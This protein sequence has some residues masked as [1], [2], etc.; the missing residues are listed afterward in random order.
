MQ[1]KQ[2]HNLKIFIGPTEIAS[3]GVILARAFREMGIRVTV[4]TMGTF[5]HQPNMNYD[6]VMDFRDLNILQNI[7]K[8]LC[9]FLKFFLC[10]N[11][12]IFLFGNSLLPYNLDLPILKLFRK[13]TI[14]LFLGSDI[15]HYESVEAEI[16]KLGIKYQ[17]NG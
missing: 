10:H 14:M 4:V 5:I 15:R 17:Q 12:F 2:N 11:T 3:I 8:R 9:H 7:Y 6:V 16:K 1:V 13:K